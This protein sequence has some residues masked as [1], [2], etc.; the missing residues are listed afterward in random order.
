MVAPPCGGAAAAWGLR[1]GD[2]ID[3]IDDQ[4][5]YSAN[6]LRA[7]LAD[8]SAQHALAV[9]RAGAPVNLRTFG[10]AP[11]ARVGREE[12]GLATSAGWTIVTSVPPGTSAYQAGLRADDR[13]VQVDK[14]ARPNSTVVQRA[15]A[16]ADTTPVFIV[17]QRGAVQRGVLIPP[18]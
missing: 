11:G 1:A 14:V 5:V 8:S 6:D 18:R 7:L 10:I 12:I 16:R 15:L 3:S 13:I 2:I 17:L 9:T 4:P